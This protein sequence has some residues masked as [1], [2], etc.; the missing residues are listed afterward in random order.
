MPNLVTSALEMLIKQELRHATQ[1]QTNF[2]NHKS[3][4]LV[5]N[6]GKNPL[7]HLTFVGAT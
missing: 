5:S 7:T 2:L 6:I 1:I 3:G 4:I